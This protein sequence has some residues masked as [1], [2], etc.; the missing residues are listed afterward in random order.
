MAIADVLGDVL[1]QGI[2]AA[3]QITL[4]KFGV[5]PNPNTSTPGGRPTTAGTGALGTVAS[6]PRW[7]WL[8]GAAG[9]G[10]LVVSRLLKR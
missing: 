9:L 2:D 3:K 8:A 5:N 7:V 1:T 4:A 10:L 6:V